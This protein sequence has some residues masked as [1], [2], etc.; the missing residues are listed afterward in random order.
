MVEAFKLYLNARRNSSSHGHLPSL[1]SQCPFFPV[2]CASAAET[3]GVGE[4]HLNEADRPCNRS[5]T[6]IDKKDFLPNTLHKY[7]FLN[8]M[9]IF[10][11][12]SLASEF[13]QGLN[14]CTE[15]RGR[16]GLSNFVQTIL[17]CTMQHKYI[18]RSAP[19]MHSFKWRSLS[20]KGN[21]Y[22]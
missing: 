16:Q 19:K 17:R 15:G 4:G 7:F 5:L 8:T 22:W 2:V 9:L 21:E 1:S 14:D 6:K 12:K 18:L 13:S 10:S 11:I 20:C 3:S